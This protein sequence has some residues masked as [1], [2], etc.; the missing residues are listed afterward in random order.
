MLMK[1][2]I[3]C[4]KPASELT[5]NI[6]P[7]S[8]ADEGINFI[9][10]LQGTADCN[11]SDTSVVSTS[12]RASLP[13]KSGGLGA[14]G[15][16]IEL[17]VEAFWQALPITMLNFYNKDK[18]AASK[19][20]AE[21]AT[22]RQRVQL[23]QGTPEPGSAL[24]AKRKEYAAFVESAE[25]ARWKSL[26][27]Q[28][29]TGLCWVFMP[30]PRQRIGWAAHSSRKAPKKLGGVIKQLL[31]SHR[32]NASTIEAQKQALLIQLEASP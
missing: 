12:L 26:Q 5:Y 7:K 29:G 14:Q 28:T 16:C 32:W 30:M 13:G 8:S 21:P 24:A 10:T 15:L 4:F 22:K 9:R 2:G 18:Q 20:L 25:C 27:L 17:F 6:L 23:R 1:M 19:R 11:K 3:A 31:K